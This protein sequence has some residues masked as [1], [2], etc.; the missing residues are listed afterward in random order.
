M[1]RMIPELAT[2]PELGFPGGRF[3]LERTI[4]SVQSWRSFERLTSYAS[5]RER[6]HLPAWQA[7]SRAVGDSGDVGIWHETY[8][9]KAGSSENIYH[10]MPPFG[11]GQVGGL[12]PAVGRDLSARGRMSGASPV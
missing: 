12:V 8:L 9:V 6:E 10:N 3:W 2:H 5:S 4:V 1:G 7:F 11:L